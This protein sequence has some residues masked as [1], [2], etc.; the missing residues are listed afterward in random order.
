MGPRP[1][2]VPTPQERAGAAA[3]ARREPR[4]RCQWI[5]LEIPAMEDALHERPP[6]RAIVLL[7]RALAQLA[8]RFTEYTRDSVSSLHPARLRHGVAAVRGV[9]PGTGRERPL[10]CPRPPRSSPSTAPRSPT[11]AT[12]LNTILVTLAAISFAHKERGLRFAAHLIR[13]SSWSSRTSATSSAGHATKPEAR[14][15]ARC[16]RSCRR[17]SWREAGRPPR[18]RGPRP[19][20]LQRV[21]S[22]RACL[23]HASP[24]SRA[25]T[26]LNTGTYLHTLVRRSKRDRDGQGHHEGG[27]WQQDDPRV[28]PVA[29]FTTWV[30]IAGV[31][32]GPVLRSVDRIG[33]LGAAL[34][35][36][37]VARIVKRRAA[38]VGLDPRELAGHS[39]RR[40][41]ATTADADGRSL[42]EIA[43]HLHHADIRTTRIYVTHP[44]VVRRPRAA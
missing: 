31:K 12:K 22:R 40:G 17:A 13:P 38:D 15:R 34:S 25:G 5:D 39:L 24:T 19:R 8:Q 28:C 36:A 26:T 11:A 29:A 21:S 10:P 4:D 2:H 44:S 35:E 18:L 14:H 20:V 43:A 6:R 7:S 27:L 42:S 37:H 9:V 3:R 41:L 23:P 16:A 32:D 30:D 1:V 33:R